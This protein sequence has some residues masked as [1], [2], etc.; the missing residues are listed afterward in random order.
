M[1]RWTHIITATLVVLMGSNLCLAQ[2]KTEQ[3]KADYERRLA[4]FEAKLDALSREKAGEY[5]DVLERLYDVLDEY[6]DYMDELAEDA[7][8]KGE[9]SLEAMKKKVR[10]G[11]YTDQPER[12]LDDIYA[13]IDEIK[14]LEN[15]LRVKY[16]SNDPKGSR[17]LRNFRRELIIIAELVEDYTDQ[18]TTSLLK[19]HEIND[20]VTAAL[21]AALRALDQAGL[22]KKGFP[23]PEPPE[24]PVI[25]KPDYPGI[26]APPATSDNA[27]S[28]RRP[29]GDRAGRIQNY[30]ANMTVT[31]SRPVIIEN[32][33][34]D[35]KI[36]GWDEETV[37]AV[38][39]VQVAANSGEKE[40]EFISRTSLKV[41]DKSDGYHIYALLPRIVDVKTELQQSTLEVNVPMHNRLVC[42][43]SY[44]TIE[45][46]ELQQDASVVAENCKVTI[47]D[48]SGAV[49]VSNSKGEIQVTGVQGAVK[50]RAS[51]A[52]MTI[53][54]CDGNIDIDNTNGTVSLSD[55][56][57]RITIVGSNHVTI[58]D[59]TGDIS[60]DNRNGPV[61][62]EDVEGNITA[63]NAYQSLS[64]RSVDGTVKVENSYGSISLTDISDIITADNNAGS[65][66]LETVRGPIDITNRMGSVS[67]MLDDDFRGRSVVKSNSGSVQVQ[68][69]AQPDLT[70]LIHTSG[71]TITSNLPIKVFQEGVNRSAELVLGEGGETL[72]LSGTASSIVISGRY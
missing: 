11:G 41:E 34:G 48:V 33:L 65:I 40:K 42:S 22:D 64:V 71:G 43:S 7:D 56:R 67:L 63:N 55:T 68:I 61:T 60:V 14:P 45:I 15:Q 6:S 50:L 28:R 10:D 19:Q 72:E 18:Q 3:S 1:A 52:P 8:F 38:L 12:L 69:A 62:I 29:S 49:N 46:S 70:L 36:T 24:V 20:Y 32:T 58:N 26:P 66:M 5:L 30:T 57:G 9:L 47:E 53:S 35:V 13:L 2:G 44:G 21:D 51:F 59:H 16:K 27:D 23:V 31:S 17:V 54:D 37:S 25:P 4:E 39:E